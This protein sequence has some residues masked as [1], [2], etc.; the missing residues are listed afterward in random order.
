MRFGILAGTSPWLSITSSRTLL[1]NQ[2]TTFG[3]RTEKE[4]VVETCLPVQASYL[5]PQTEPLALRME[6]LIQ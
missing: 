2:W 5:L 6:R 1:T 4:N 3:V